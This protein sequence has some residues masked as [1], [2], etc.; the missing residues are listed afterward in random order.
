MAL[1]RALL[2]V[3]AFAVQELTFRVFHRNQLQLEVPRGLRHLRGTQESHSGWKGSLKAHSVSIQSCF[4]STASE[5]L[6]ISIN[7]GYPGILRVR[8]QIAT[9]TRRRKSFWLN[10]C[11]HKL[12]MP[13]K[14]SQIMW[15][16]EQISGKSSTRR[17]FLQCTVTL[18][19][20]LLYML[21]RL[22][23]RAE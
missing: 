20:T 15:H 7:A 19:P 10:K 5:R 16:C 21:A 17:Y 12:H 13:V 6:F 2:R 9:S 22:N 4:S 23:Y 14:T 8:C 3:A 18:Q 1:G 11:L